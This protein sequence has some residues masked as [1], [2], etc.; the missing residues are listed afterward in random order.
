MRYTNEVRN[1]AV[2]QITLH[3][4]PLHLFPE[5]AIFWPRKNAL[6]IADVHLGKDDVFRARG[7]PIP[8]GAADETFARLDA[9]LQRAVLLHKI[10]SAQLI[11]LGDFLHARESANPATLAAFLKWRQAH[12]S[13][14]IVV[15]E[16]NHDRH[17]GTAKLADAWGIRIER[18]PFLMTPFALCHEVHADCSAS[19]QSY[20]L[21]GH[22]HPCVL[23]RS[24]VDRLRV[25]C[26]VLGERSGVL[27]AFGAFT[28]GFNVSPRAGESIFAITGETVLKVPSA[29]I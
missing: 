7:V 3:D 19:A 8:H 12:P 20:A 13:L 22:T 15:V 21:S 2:M 18:E 9:A 6:I 16:G 28:G 25:P 1:N 23:L 5:R 11:V 27:P 17:A 10:P 29:Q 24:M 4:E 26:F 14:S